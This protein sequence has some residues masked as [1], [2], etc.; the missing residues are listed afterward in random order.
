MKEPTTY[1]LSEMPV[2]PNPYRMRYYF[3]DLKEGDVRL[4]SVKQ[5]IKIRHAAYQ[6]GK[7]NKCRMI[8]RRYWHKNKWWTAVQKQE[9]VTNQIP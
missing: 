3:S 5:I 4:Y 7:K 9:I 8:V 2:I 6:Y 1:T